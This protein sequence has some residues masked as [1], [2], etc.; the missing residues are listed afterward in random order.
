[1]IYS[2]WA[3]YRKPN[4]NIRMVC[5]AENPSR[6]HPERFPTYSSICKNDAYALIA[7]SYMEIQGKHEIIRTC[8]KSPIFGKL[9]LDE[10]W[11]SSKIHLYFDKKSTQQFILSGCVLWPGLWQF[12]GMYSDYGN[13]WR[14]SSLKECQI[15]HAFQYISQIIY[16]KICHYW[17]QFWYNIM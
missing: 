13:N 6:C 5:A 3:H 9:C 12:S 15:F 14:R 8:S 2:L 16:Y 10:S 17:E 11:S 4:I 7:H 1:M